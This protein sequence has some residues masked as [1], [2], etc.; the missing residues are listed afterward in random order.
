M[1]RTFIRLPT[2]EKAWKALSLTEDD[3][4]ELENMLLKNPTI[5]KVLEGSGGIRKVRYALPYTGKSGGIRVIYLD[6]LLQE[7][8]Y[9]LYAYPKSAKENLTQAEIGLYKKIATEIK[10]VF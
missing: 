2:F 9:L 6:I 8:T 5:G 7:T 10:K 1:I 4:I 3:Y